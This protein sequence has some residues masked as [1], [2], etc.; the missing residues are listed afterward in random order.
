VK[1]EIKRSEE[2]D[3]RD[4]DE[5][6]FDPMSNGEFVNSMQYLSYHPEGR[7][8]DASVAIVDADTNTV[9]S[10]FP[11]ASDRSRHSVV[12]HPGTTFAGM[13]YNLR[14]LSIEELENHID[15]LIS[16]YR[17]Q[18]FLKLEMRLPSIAYHNQ[19]EAKLIFLLLQKKFQIKGSHL[20]NAIKLEKI[21]NEEDL[22]KQYLI[23]RRN[24][25]KKTLNL[26]TLKFE[27]WE[28]I[29]PS[30]WDHLSDHLIQ[31]FG[32]G[33]THSLDEINIL[34]SKFP[35]QIVP[36]GVTEKETNQYGALGLIFKYKQVFHTQYLDTN[37]E[38]STP[39]PNFFLIHHLILTAVEE[40]YSV[41]SFGASTEKWGSVLNKGLFR[42]KDEFGGGS[43][44]LTRLVLDLESALS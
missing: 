40:G 1:L 10:V 13:I 11:A 43:I 33:P 15:L 34:C 42:Y 24:R 20:I 35:E 44:L 41:F 6:I 32:T 7:F 38:L 23:K 27:K 12:S 17:E 18:G 25:I 2:I 21:H 5:L 14:N 36:Y 31:K 39:Y 19:P 37:F 28:K 4:W 8:T 26:Q 30:V 22:I 9:K 29:E 3:Q 16:H